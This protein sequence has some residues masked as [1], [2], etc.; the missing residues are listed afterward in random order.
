MRLFATKENNE[1]VN[2]NCPFCLTKPLLRSH[3]LTLFGWK[4]R[5]FISLVNLIAL[6]YQ[7]RDDYMNLQS[8]EVGSLFLRSFRL[9]DLTA[10]NAVAR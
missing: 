8:E 5:D 6:Y 4:Y 10:L 3:R 1:Y 2:L 9:L 7:I